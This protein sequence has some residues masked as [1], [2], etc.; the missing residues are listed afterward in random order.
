MRQEAWHYHSH[1]CCANSINISDC[2]VDALV[3]AHRSHHSTTCPCSLDRMSA[4][5]A[6]PQFAGVHVIALDRYGPGGMLPALWGSIRVC[7]RVCMDAPPWRTLSGSMGLGALTGGV[8]REARLHPRLFLI[9]PTGRDA[10]DRW[11]MNVDP[12]RKWIGCERCASAREEIGSASGRGW[13][14]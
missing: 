9:S 2:H 10:G 11:S 5:L 7:V 4:A 13:V 3:T 14:G 12:L 8:R 1:V 6:T